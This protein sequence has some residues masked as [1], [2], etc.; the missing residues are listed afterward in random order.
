MR[1][2]VHT[3]AHDLRRDQGRLAVGVLEGR[4]L[5]RVTNKAISAL[6]KVGHMKLVLHLIRPPRVSES[7]L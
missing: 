6:S 7:Q 4:H 3:E 1:T 5:M 2:L